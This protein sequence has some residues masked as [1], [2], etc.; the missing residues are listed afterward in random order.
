MADQLDTEQLHRQA[1]LAQLGQPT[2]QTQPVGTPVPEA[3]AAPVNT[4]DTRNALGGYAGV[5]QMNG[6]NTAGYGDDTKAANSVKNTFGRIASRY[7]HA[8]GSLDQIFAD[9]D[10]QRYFPNARRVQ[11]GAGD[12]ID[13]GG[14]LSDFESGVP[15]G[16]VDVL[17]G[18][19]PSNN[20]SQGWQW[21]DLA[22]AAGAGSAAPQAT[23]AAQGALNTGGVDQLAG[24]DNLAQ[25]LRQIQALSDGGQDPM[26]RDALMQMLGGGI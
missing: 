19:D 12:Q 14:I 8:P 24:Q 15:V 21:M 13:F 4:R 22:S 5:G 23:Q 18:S 16:I 9:A 6:F 2:N 17:Q 20:S 11:G 7:Q 26:Q 10:F 25:I 3:P 1:M